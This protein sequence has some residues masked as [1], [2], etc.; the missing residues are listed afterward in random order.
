VSDIQGPAYVISSN[1][2]K[3]T[4]SYI[5]DWCYG[6]TAH[7]GTVS[8]DDPRQIIKRHIRERFDE[9]NGLPLYFVSDHGNISRQ[10]RVTLRKR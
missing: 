9:R 2:Y 6:K 7:L 4:V 1:G 8:V 10:R 5:D 3:N